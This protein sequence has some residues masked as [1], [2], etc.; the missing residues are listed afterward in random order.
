MFYII[1]ILFAFPTF[2]P[3][4]SDIY[5][6]LELALASR[7]LRLKRN[8]IFQAHLFD[9]VYHSLRM[10]R[11]RREKAAAIRAQRRC[12]QHIQAQTVLDERKE[13][14]DREEQ[15][16]SDSKSSLQHTSTSPSLS[17]SYA[18]S[19]I[20]DPFPSIPVVPPNMAHILHLARLVNETRYDYS[21]LSRLLSRDTEWNYLISTIVEPEMAMQFP[22]DPDLDE[23]E[24]NSLSANT[25]QNASKLSP[26]EQLQQLYITASSNTA[27]AA[28]EAAHAAGAP[29][30]SQQLTLS[31]NALS[32]EDALVQNSGQVT[33]MLAQRDTIAAVDTTVRGEALVEAPVI[34]ALGVSSTAALM[35]SLGSIVEG[36]KGK[37]VQP[38]TQKEKPNTSNT[39]HESL[40]NTSSNSTNSSH[41]TPAPA[42][43][44]SPRTNSS[45]LPPTSQTKTHVINTSTPNFTVTIKE[46]SNT[47][48]M[49]S[50][51]DDDFPDF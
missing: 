12:R 39:T 14:A 32:A 7:G 21:T 2:S 17:S 47:V 16:I 34:A 23:T 20:M 4:H 13:E 24:Q 18:V 10:E 45:S 15:R 36:N 8:V 42:S 25:T 9:R 44:K 27:S 31:F 3:L 51:D 6:F 40:N 1:S 22:P 38:D 49:G 26:N 35:G 33:R 28:A 11:K 29:P 48:G 43:S 37:L 41:S 50:N 30:P 46:S 5:T 19:A